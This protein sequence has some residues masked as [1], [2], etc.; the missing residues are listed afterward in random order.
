[1]ENFL[2]Q[3]DSRKKE[4]QEGFCSER[5]HNLKPRTY[6]HGHVRVYA[7]GKQNLRS[8]G[9]QSFLR[10]DGPF[11]AQSLVPV[12]LVHLSEEQVD[13]PPQPDESPASG[14]YQE[15]FHPSLSQLT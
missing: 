12:L 7:E 4:E 2:G 11:H 14:G 10:N 1:M 5:R 6:G 15:G 9:E 3:D 13:Q 8:V